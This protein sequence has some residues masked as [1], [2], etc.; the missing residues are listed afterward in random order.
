MRVSPWFHIGALLVAFGDVAPLGAAQGEAPGVSD[1]ARTYLADNCFVCHQG[2]KAEGGL[3]LSRVSLDLDSPEQV[4][5]WVQVHDRVQ[6][7]EMPPYEAPPVPIVPWGWSVRAHDEGERTAWDEDQL[8]LWNLAN[9]LVRADAQRVAREGRAEVRRLNR[10]E[11]ENTLRQVLDAP[12]LL[13]ADRLPD[14]GVENLF[15]KSGRRLDVSHV[16]LAAYMDVAEQAIRSAVQAAAHPSQTRRSYAREEDIFQSYLF[17]RTGQMAATRS[18]V[19]L[20]GLTPEVDILRKIAPVTVGDQDPEKREREAMGVFS[21]TY[22]A[23]TKYDFM[24]NAARSDGRYRLRF[25]TYTFMAGPNGASGGG[26][27]GLTGGDR[28]WWQPDRNVAF[29]GKRTEPVTLYAL[30]PSGESRWL[31]TFDS[32]PEPTVFECEVTLRRGEGI[33]PDATRLVRTRPGFRGNPNALPEGV[34]G[35]A[36][37]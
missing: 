28:S 35:L 9:D 32:Q 11:Y 2:S 16:Q 31:T 19:P 20:D 30:T 13:I 3:D 27:Q 6:A 23:T 22:S 25:K 4:E 10:L 26:D 24:G 7:G 29:A 36:M 1:A 8:F 17:Y 33:R 12:W 34:P 14:D 5:L 15:T 18:I 21:G 37:N